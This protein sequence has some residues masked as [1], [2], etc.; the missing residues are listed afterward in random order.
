MDET[1]TFR[2]RIVSLL[3]DG[4]RVDASEIQYLESVVQ[5]LESIPR[6]QSRYRLALGLHQAIDLDLRYE[7]D[8]LKK[9]I[10]FLKN[11]ENVFIEYLESLLP[12]LKK[13]A[14][15]L[16]E[17][18]KN[19]S[20]KTC[21]TDRDGTINNYCG[22]YRSSIQSIYNAVFIS[23]FAKKVDNAVLVS[24]APLEGIGLVDLCVM[25][26]SL[27][28][29]AGSK[30]RDYMNKAGTRRQ[31]P[32]L[33]SQHVKLDELNERLKEIVAHEEYE[34]Y[35]LIG[36]GLQRTFGQTTIAR[37]DIFNSIPH[38]ESLS[39]LAM[40]KKEV[41]SIDPEGIFFRI[42]DTGKDIEIM[43]TVENEKGAGVKDFDKGDGL[44]FLNAD[45]RLEMER[46]RTLMC[47]DTFS[48]LPM[49]EASLKLSAETWV[50]FVTSDEALK[51]SVKALCANSFFLS[52]PDALVLTLHYVSESS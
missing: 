40:I 34:K 3:L 14:A 51:K 6:C 44:H 19:V 11:Q 9:D 7:I 32:A 52:S 33:M 37:Q 21:I 35:A 16:S 47:G 46:G 26:H 39:F 15:V 29:Y 49:V 20:F 45:C 43:L 31:L 28:I 13:E 36:S 8:E 38:D 50:V 48:D 24:A 22:R 10:F 41:A 23:Q 4:G 2:S 18:I 42:N 12:G 17:A 30:G 5:A 1:R 25:P 27:F